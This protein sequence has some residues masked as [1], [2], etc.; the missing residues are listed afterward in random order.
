MKGEL[1]TGSGA[2]YAANRMPNVRSPKWA[3]VAL[4]AFSLLVMMD[5]ARGQ[6]IICSQTTPGSCPSGYYCDNNSMCIP[7]KQGSDKTTT[8][9]ILGCVLGGIVIIVTVII[10]LYCGRWRWL[11][12]LKERFGRQHSPDIASGT[13]SAHQQMPKLNW[14]KSLRKRFKLKLGGIRS[15]PYMSNANQGISMPSSQMNTATPVLNM[16]PAPIVNPAVNTA[17]T[18]LNTDMTMSTNMAVNVNTA[19]NSEAANQETILTRYIVG[20]DNSQNRD[21]QSSNPSPY[22]ATVELI[23]NDIEPM[24]NP[25]GQSIQLTNGMNHFG[26]PY[27]SSSRHSLNSLETFQDPG[28]PY[29][30]AVTQVYYPQPSPRLMRPQINIQSPIPPEPQVI[31]PA[32]PMDVPAVLEPATPPI[33]PHTHQVYP[34]LYPSLGHG[35][36]HAPTTALPAY[37]EVPRKY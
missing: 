11:T 33:V 22:V 30:Q 24:I 14:A 26:Y 5:S 12:R 25:Q 3:C 7:L 9:V 10:I 13:P 31:M 34:S 35:H 21:F 15:N 32:Q 27:L 19:T 1:P 20:Q 36:T 18:A 4:L 8:Y 29:H 28:I 17:N 6:Q 23:G 16:T 2:L 37:A